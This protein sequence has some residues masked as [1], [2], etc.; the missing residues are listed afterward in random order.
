M[1]LKLEKQTP[2]RIL[3]VTLTFATIMA[4]IWRS[5][6]DAGSVQSFNRC[7]CFFRDAFPTFIKLH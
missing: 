3:R 4:W 2:Y 7:L 1:S 6:D 5:L